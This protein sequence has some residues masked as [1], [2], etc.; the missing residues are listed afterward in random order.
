[1]VRNNRERLK[2]IAAEHAVSFVQDGM[3]LGLGSGTT[4]AHFIDILGER[5]RS[6]RL[7]DVRG[8]PTSEATARRARAADIPLVSLDD[9]ESLD[10]VVDGA[11][12][13]DPHL[14]LI[15]GRGRALLRE[16]IVGI[17]ARQFVIIVDESKLVDRL[18][19]QGPLPVEILPFAAR[20]HLRWLQSLGCR[21]EL[22]VEPSG[23]PVVTDNGNFLAMCYFPRGI[24]RPYAL[25]E[26][27]NAR[28]GIIEHGLF[29]DMADM[30]VV[31]TEEG[32]RLLQKDPGAGR[33]GV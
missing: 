24:E 21:A 28:P 30:V 5:L 31:G 12:E 27:L 19:S 23:E 15:K 25:A 4:M 18:G 11:D 32:V 29:L 33:V 17:H 16:K 26:A 7:R 2:R 14:N 8:V 22:L 9:Y 13:V 6:H 3:V 10:L 1:M 20:S